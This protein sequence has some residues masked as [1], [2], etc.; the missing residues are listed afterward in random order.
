MDFVIGSEMPSRLKGIETDRKILSN[1][2]ISF[3]CSEMPS[4]LK[5]I[6]T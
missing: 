5:G 2:V 1:I 3:F 4:R 6:E